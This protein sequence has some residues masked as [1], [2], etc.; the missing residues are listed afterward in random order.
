MKSV[1][2]HQTI[3]VY[4]NFI[5][6]K[7]E[8]ITRYLLFKTLLVLCMHECLNRHDQIDLTKLK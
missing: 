4:K 7:L 3:A 1:F 5:L 6:K 2:F 8:I